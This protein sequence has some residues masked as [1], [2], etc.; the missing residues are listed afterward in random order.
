MASMIIKKKIISQTACDENKKKL[1]EEYPGRP[2][3][4]SRSVNTS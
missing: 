1:E 4:D 3:I 2:Q